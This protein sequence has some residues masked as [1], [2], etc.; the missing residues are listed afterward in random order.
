MLVVVSENT[1][2]GPIVSS[3]FKFGLRLKIPIDVFKDISSQIELAVD[4][5]WIFRVGEFT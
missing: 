3:L 5:I 1:E 4:Q 2:T